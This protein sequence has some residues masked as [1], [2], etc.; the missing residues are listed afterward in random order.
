L[1]VVWGLMGL[2]ET[3]EAAT[4]G[5]WRDAEWGGLVVEAD[6]ENPIAYHVLRD[7][8]RLI[9]LAPELAALVLDMGE[10]IR[11]VCDP[12]DEWESSLLARLDQLGKEPAN[13]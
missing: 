10:F 5:P 11:N 7:N 6:T 4:P 8:A 13:D 9:A 2:R 3:L 12:T 1:V